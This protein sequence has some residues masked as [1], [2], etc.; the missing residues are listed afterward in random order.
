[1]RRHKGEKVRFRIGI[2]ERFDGFDLRFLYVHEFLIAL[3]FR[4]P[5]GDSRET[6]K[7]PL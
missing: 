4:V 6:S 7:S 1:M 2:R 5:L 3:A